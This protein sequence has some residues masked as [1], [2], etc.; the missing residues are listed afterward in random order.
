VTTERVIGARDADLEQKFRE[1]QNSRRSCDFILTRRD[2][3]LTSRHD[4]RDDLVLS[5][6]QRSFD[7]ACEFFSRNPVSWGCEA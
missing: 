7:A 4:E 2:L 6:T 5:P 3:Y 1:I